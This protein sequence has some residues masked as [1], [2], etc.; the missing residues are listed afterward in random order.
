[1]WTNLRNL[2]EALKK[3]P[4][5]QGASGDEG[6]WD[7]LMEWLETH[8]LTGFLD[9]IIKQVDEIVDIDPDLP[10]QKILARATRYIVE[11]LGASS[12]SVRIYDPQSEQM[13]SSGSFP[14]QE[15]HRETYIP[16]EGSIAG[17]VVKSGKPCLV[18]NIL[19]DKRYEDKRVVYRRGIHSLMAIPL[20]IPRF[21]PS[22]RDTRG[23]IQVYFP[24]KDREFSPLEIKIA[25][26]LAKRLSFVIARKKI[27]S[28]HRLNEKKEAIVRHIFRRLG[29]RGGI[30]MKDVFN[31]VI[32]ELA[33]VANVQ[34]CALF[35][36]TGD[37]QH[38]TL[39]ACYPEGTGCHGIGKKFA[40][41]SEPAFEI[42]LGLREYKGDSSYEVVTPSYILVVNPQKSRIISDHMKK[43][44]A[45]HNINSMLYIPL[46]VEGEITHFMTFD[47]IEQ[48]Q[49]YRD[50][51]I[52]LFL[53]LGQE[54]MKAQRME[55]LDD[56]LHDFKNPAIASAGFA[57]RLKKI[58]EDG[59]YKEHEEQIKRY[60]DILFEETS[61]MQELALSIYAVGKEQVVDMTKI[62]L[63]RF[64]INKEAIKEQ[65]KQNVILREGPFAWNLN[66][67]CF[68]IHLERV[69]DNLLNNATKAI[70]MRGG[71]LSI[72]TYQDGEWACAEITNTGRIPEEDRKRLVQGQG[73]EG[74]GLYI[75]Y[76]IMRLL[77]G[78]IEVESTKSSTTFVVRLPIHQE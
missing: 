18:P 46:Y 41:S 48:R 55:R 64:E 31:Q 60:L 5:A 13:L 22:E 28:L 61:R 26:L 6:F 40:V 69:F 9:Q 37:Y 52:E 59:N 65:L 72:R 49:R 44:A 4:W 14:S 21:F 54:L 30:K 7:S 63:K 23:V 36:V 66:V 43:F 17:E 75:T 15:K 57:R 25:E 78:K 10:E 11:F 77:G 42:I 27:I 47:A 39:E 29:S 19:N 35:S 58:L 62:L 45:G 16:L 12:A 68:P 56:I 24:E 3:E 73:S 33:D 1:M 53:F 70:P 2:V 76:R 38:V 71:V 20:E 34:S 50:D 67:S 32:P 8:L 51:E 74:R